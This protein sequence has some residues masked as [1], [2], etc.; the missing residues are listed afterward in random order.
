MCKVCCLVQ[1][2]TYAIPIVQHHSL[3]WWSFI[4]W[5]AFASLSKICECLFL[6]SLFYSL[7]HINRCVLLPVCPARKV[8]QYILPINIVLHL[9]F[10]HILINT[11]CYL[12]F[13][14]FSIYWTLPSPHKYFSF[15]EMPLTLSYNWLYFLMT[16]QYC[17]HIQDIDLSLLMLQIVSFRF[18]VIFNSFVV[19]DFFIFM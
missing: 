8:Y 5:I 14:F 17:L 9:P 18:L 10:L 6:S 2:F 1:F 3:K 11:E 13:K 15:D 4:Y 16:C 19:Q 7:L 12:S